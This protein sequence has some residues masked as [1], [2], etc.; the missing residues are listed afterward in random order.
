MKRSPILALLI[1]VTCC[2][3]ASTIGIQ[4]KILNCGIFRFSSKEEVISSPETP[5]GITRVPAG[6]PIFVSA[7]NRI[8]ARIG[9][10]FGMTYEINNLP[11]PDGEVEITKIAK[12]PLITKPDGTTSTGFTF[13]EKQ[14]VKDGHVVGWTGYGFDHDYELATGRWEFEMQFDGK[15]L[16]KQEFVVFK[17]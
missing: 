14:L 1:F 5:S 17:E 12:H 6:A 3:V 13:V 10:R 15:T 4:S 8:P 9:I 2:C 7:T 11:V 16:C